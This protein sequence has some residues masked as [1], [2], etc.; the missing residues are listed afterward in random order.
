MGFVY[1]FDYHNDLH[2]LEFSAVFVTHIK[3]NAVLP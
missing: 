2:S 3:Y 1:T